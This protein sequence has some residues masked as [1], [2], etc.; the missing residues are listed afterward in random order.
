MQ[1]ELDLQ[2]DTGGTDSGP[3]SRRADRRK[4][5]APAPRPP[6]SIQARKIPRCDGWDGE[7]G[8]ET[9]R[10]CPARATHRVEYDGKRE[11]AC[12]G[13]L[14]MVLRWA[15]NHVRWERRYSFRDV[16]APVIHRLEFPLDK[17]AAA[18]GRRLYVPY[19]QQLLGAI[20]PRLF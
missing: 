15:D 8:T 16:A 3:P 1:A 20:A 18:Y 9:W 17:R 19:E 7:P 6:K 5:Q 10:W 2:L 14:A 12:D 4:S 11:H 13:H